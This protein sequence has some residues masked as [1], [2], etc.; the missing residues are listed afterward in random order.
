M[1]SDLITSKLRTAD[2]LALRADITTET[3]YLIELNSTLIR[4]DFSAR[5]I[6]HPEYGLSIASTVKLEVEI[7]DNALDPEHSYDLESDGELFVLPLEEDDGELDED[8]AD[9]LESLQHREGMVYTED[10]YY[11]P[12]DGEARILYGEI[13]EP[14]EE[15]LEEAGVE[16]FGVWYSPSCNGEPDARAYLI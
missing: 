1:N 15:E 6:V 2:A 13:G 10:Y 3:E 12:D 8:V 11:A 7:I 9:Q 16:L 5:F 14:D 4:D